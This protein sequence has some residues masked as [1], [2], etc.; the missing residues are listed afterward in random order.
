MALSGDGTVSENGTAAGVPAP[1]RPEPIRLG[2]A[3]W[4]R[5]RCDQA[6]VP[7]RRVP[8]HAARAGA[9]HRAAAARRS[10]A[11]RARI[12]AS[13]AAVPPVV[14]SKRTFD[15]CATT[16]VHSFVQSTATA[17]VVG[18]R[19]AIYL[20]DAAPAGL[21]ADR[22][23]RGRRALRRPPLSH[24]HDRLRP[25]VGSRR[26]RRRH[27]AADPARQ[28]ALAP[29]ATRPAASSSA[30]S[31]AL[32]LLAGQDRHSNDGEIF[33]GAVP[34]QDMPN[35]TIVHEGRRHPVAPAGVHPRVPAH[36]QLQPARAGA[37]G[38]RR[39][40]L[41]QRRAVPFRRGAGGR[42]VPDAFCTG[43]HASA[44]IS[45]SAATS[46]TPTAT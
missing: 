42:D 36:D 44:R 17:K 3:R 6:R 20:D 25:R 28:R 27:R 13:V 38:Q 24:R 21:H 30:F 10:G 16:D 8:R 12:S 45:S 15:V 41:A 18:Q 29:T 34:R 33:Y 40:D 14:G 31:S 35:C 11:S 2:G 5:P 23:G 32:D 43:V 39:G 46:P 1:G 26:Q 19:V 9:D 22:H 37:R 7:G 4:A